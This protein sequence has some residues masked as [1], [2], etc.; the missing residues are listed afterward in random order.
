MTERMVRTRLLPCRLHCLWHT[1]ELQRSA[2]SP[3]LTCAR[4]LLRRPL[5]PPL[6]APSRAPRP[7]SAH[8]RW[9]RRVRC[10]RRLLPGPPGRPGAALGAGR[11]RHRGADA[12]RQG[13]GAATVAGAAPGALQARRPPPC[14]T[15]WLQAVQCLSMGTLWGALT[16]PV[17]LHRRREQR[18]GAATEQLAH[19]QAN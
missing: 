3:A 2:F 16:A 12:R 1:A 17:A 7:R 11:A 4:A 6:G 8:F 18:R 13:G 9:H 14:Q 5:P 19:P 10:G 15:A